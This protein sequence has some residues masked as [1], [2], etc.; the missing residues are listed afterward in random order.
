MVAQ[1]VWFEMACAAPMARFHLRRIR[2]TRV[3]AVRRGVIA[4]IIDV[5]VKINVLHEL[6]IRAI[7]QLA[8][9]TGHEQS[10]RIR[11][12]KPRLED[13]FTRSR[14]LKSI[15]STELLPSAATKSCFLPSNPK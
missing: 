4:Q 14:A 10:F 11:K 9:A 6:E 3:H 2:H 1:F 7:A 5:P 15:T 8:F 12:R 13:S